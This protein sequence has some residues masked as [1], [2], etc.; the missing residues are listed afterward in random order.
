MREA[1]RQAPGARIMAPG[2][3]EHLAGCVIGHFI[4]IFELV[5]DFGNARAGD[6]PHVV[7]PPVD[8]LIGFAVIR[9]PAKIGRVNISG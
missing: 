5:G 8:T 9:S 1:D 2:Q 7:V 4:I 6:R 3:I